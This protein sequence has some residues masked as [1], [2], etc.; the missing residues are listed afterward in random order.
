MHLSV[1]IAAETTAE[2]KIAG[3]HLESTVEEWI[4][5]THLGTTAESGTTAETHRR[6]FAEEKDPG[7]QKPGVGHS[8]GEPNCTVL[9]S[10][11]DCK[12]RTT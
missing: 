4:F 1:T 9:P 10:G 8:T 12:G 2:E 6:K 5:A 3:V 11:L 7:R